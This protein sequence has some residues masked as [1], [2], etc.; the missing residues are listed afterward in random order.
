MQ[1]STLELFT[2]AGY[3]V[4]IPEPQRFPRM[5]DDKISGVLFRSQEISRYV[6]DGSIDCGL[7]RSR[8]DCRKWQ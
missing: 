8:L 2:R 3:K 1:S 6:A 7:M 4:T 5:D